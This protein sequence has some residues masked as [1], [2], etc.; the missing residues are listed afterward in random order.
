MQEKRCGLNQQKKQKMTLKNKRRSEKRQQ[1][2]AGIHSL[3]S[4]SDEEYKI[5][6]ETY[7]LNKMDVM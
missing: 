2:E 5:Y 6:R 1:V 3:I 7:W 4:M